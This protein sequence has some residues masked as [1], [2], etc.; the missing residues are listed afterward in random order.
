MNIIKFWYSLY[1]ARV[2]KM[3]DQEISR[4]VETLNEAECNDPDYDERGYCRSILAVYCRYNVPSST[5]LKEIFAG[6]SSMQCFLKNVGKR[7][8]PLTDEEQQAIV[9]LPE[10][11][12]S[13]LSCPLSSRYEIRLIE[14]AKVDVLMA[15][16]KK[17]KLS[18]AAER[19]LIRLCDANHD[20]V[21]L[22]EYYVDAHHGKVFTKQ[23]AQQLLFEVPHCDLI[24]K[25]LIE[26]STMHQP[27]LFDSSIEQL[28]T[29]NSKRQLLLLFLSHSYVA[30][31][32]LLKRLQSK[33]SD[34]QLQALVEIS[35]KRQQL[36]ENLQSSDRCLLTAMEKKILTLD[37]AEE[38]R[39]HVMRQIVPKMK[40]GETSPVMAAWVA[41]QYP[42][43]A[44]VAAIAT[45]IFV[46]R[47][48]ERAVYSDWIR[49][50]N[51]KY[52]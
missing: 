45:G 30:N 43:L 20:Y 26:H 22:A 23:D 1:R 8:Q 16:L 2:G 33:K 24:Q 32:Q 27:L 29:K 50:L 40:K 13:A 19:Q 18:L 31:P 6:D 7:K 12:F 17:F 3:D 52:T 46:K 15:Y 41:Y 10:Y 42:N 38:Q 36:L 28:I 11:C 51:T 49:S 14:W 9:E 5:L 4:L 44:Q 25:A 34:K 39:Q 21:W 47:I 35:L 48:K 37:K